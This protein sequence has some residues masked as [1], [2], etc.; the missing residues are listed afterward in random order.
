MT[1]D[2]F[3]QAIA[4]ANPESELAR[5]LPQFKLWYSQAGTP[6]L[7]VETAYDAQ[8]QTF[9]LTFTQTVPDTPGQS[10]SLIHI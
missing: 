6:R 5:Q 9:S 8:A 3:A 4:D 7:R 1:C 10:L 2:D